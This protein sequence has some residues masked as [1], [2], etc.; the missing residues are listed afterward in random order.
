[1]EED[2]ASVVGQQYRN[3]VVALYYRE[4]KVDIIG[5]CL[6]AGGIGLADRELACGVGPYLHALALLSGQVGHQIVAH[7]Q[8]EAYKSH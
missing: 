5:R 3:G 2:I 4:K 6:A 7:I 8:K 1:M